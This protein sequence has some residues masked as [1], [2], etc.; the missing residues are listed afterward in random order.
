MKIVLF[1]A[2]ALLAFAFNSILCRLALAGGEADA[3]SFTTVRLLSGAAAL[4]LLSA[5][6]GRSKTSTR[7]GSWP[8]AFLL[9]AYAFCFSLAYLGLTAATGALI[10]F[11]SVQLTMIAV[12]F[13]RGDRPSLLEL[14][15]LAVAAG[16]LVYLVLPGLESPPLVSSLLMAAAG[17]AWGGYTLRGKGDADPLP[18]T[19]GNFVRSL[20]FM[21]IALPFFLDELHISASGTFLAIVS[22]AIASGVGYAVWYSALRGLTSTRAAVSQLLVPVISALMAVPM[23][24]E[25][26][27]IHLAAAGSLILSGVAITITGRGQRQI[28]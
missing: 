3:A 17:A 4:A 25:I 24:G 16:G 7:L 6:L 5:V 8:S 2:L 21:M 13:A 11:G 10:L 28:T 19:A 22:G 9:F 18:E 14:S 12:S 15:G 1:T 26:L 23:L 27:T 20:P